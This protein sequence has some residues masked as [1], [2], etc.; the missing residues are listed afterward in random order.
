[1]KVVI[2]ISCMYQFDYSI[3]ERTNVQTDAVVINQCD[4]EGITDFDILNNKGEKCHIKYINTKERGLSRSRN[5]AIKNAWGDI[6]YL[7]DDDELLEDNYESIIIEAYKKK[8]LV[9]IIAFSLVRK[10]YT[11]PKKAGKMCIPQILR[12]S[13]VQTTIRRNRLLEKGI[14]FDVKMGS[15]SGNGGGE[16]NKFLMDCRRKGL[17]LYYVPSII[18]TV[19]SEESQWFKGFDE[20]YFKDTFWAARRI[21]GTSIGFLY[22]LYWCFIRSNHFNIEI[23][24]LTMLKYSL[25]GFFEKR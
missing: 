18:A 10:G 16:E 12:T 11:Y 25:M 9:D 5:M 17:K 23:P 8:P 3:I 20:K 24:K 15:G 2:L 6:L 21:L 1:M 4:K 22:M 7:C 13:S 19:K 14:F